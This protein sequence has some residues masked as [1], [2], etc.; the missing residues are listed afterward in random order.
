MV[1]VI[2]VALDVFIACRVC[3][4]LE[5]VDDEDERVGYAHNTPDGD[6]EGDDKRLGAILESG[7][8]V[9]DGEEADEGDE[10]QCVH[11][12]VSC[13]VGEVVHQLAARFAKLP[14]ELVVVCC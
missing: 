13:Y 9:Y 7:L 4:W 6:D 5:T 10:N 14:P 2:Q 12:H 1:E 3:V 11:R 8:V